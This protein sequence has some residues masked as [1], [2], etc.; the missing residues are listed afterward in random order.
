ML[1]SANTASY[2]FTP[3]PRVV[4][5]DDP[6]TET[7]T[8]LPEN[9]DGEKAAKEL[10]SEA[11]PGVE[12]ELSPDEQRQVQ[13]LESRDREVKAHEAAHMAAAAGLVRGGMSFSYQT[14][15]DGQRYAV[16]GEVSIDSSPVAGDPQATLAKASQIQAAALA[17]ADPSAQDRAVA[18]SAAQM[19][20]EARLELALQ[21]NEERTGAAQSVDSANAISAYQLAGQEPQGSILDQTV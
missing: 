4:F 3:Q 13:G 20:M 7:D 9:S 17:P 1:I 5:S 15:P 21:Q 8:D 18:A 14:G 19:A 2:P 16:G 11:S 12:Q 10:G 6:H